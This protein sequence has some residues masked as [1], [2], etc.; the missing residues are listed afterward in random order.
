MNTVL[1]AIALAGTT[2][3]EH[4][5]LLRRQTTDREDISNEC[6]AAA[7]SFLSTF[8]TPGPSLPEFSSSYYQ[9][10]SRTANNPDG[11]C[12]WVTSVPEAL[13]TEVI[14]YNLEVLEW[15]QDDENVSLLEDMV[16]ECPGRESATTSCRE[17]WDALAAK[18]I[19]SKLLPFIFHTGM[20]V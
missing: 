13:Y 2:L 3:A 8:P 14:D 18:I 10:A 1:I 15:F 7:S 20:W 4:P 11:D 19:D 12:A 6:R 5:G 17:E 9:T 16:D